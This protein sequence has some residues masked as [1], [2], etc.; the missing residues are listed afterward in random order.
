M[1]NEQCP[2]PLNIHDLHQGLSYALGNMSPRDPFYQILFDRWVE[3]TPGGLTMPDI[4][5]QSKVMPDRMRKFVAPLAKLAAFASALYPT[6][7]YAT[8]S[9]DGTGGQS[10]P[11]PPSIP[12]VD[13]DTGTP[14]TLFLPILSNGHVSTTI[15]FQNEHGQPSD[16]TPTTSVKPEG[17]GKTIYL[18]AVM[19]GEVCK[20]FPFQFG[21]GVVQVANNGMI[22]SVGFIDQGQ[23]V[24][25]NIDENDSA[26][27]VIG[28]VY[29]QVRPKCGEGGKYILQ[30]NFSVAPVGSPYDSYNLIGFQAQ[31]LTVKSENPRVFALTSAGLAPV[32]GAPPDLTVR[33]GDVLEI[34]RIWIG[35]DGAR[36]VVYQDR[37][38]HQF[39]MTADEFLDPD[40][41]TLPAILRPGEIYGED[42]APGYKNAA[43]IIDS[44]L[45]GELSKNGLSDSEIASIYQMITN[46]KEFAPGDPNI[47]IAFGNLNTGDGQGIVYMQTD[48]KTKHITVDANAINGLTID[49]ILSMLAHELGHT[50]GPYGEKYLNSNNFL[51]LTPIFSIIGYRTSGEPIVLNTENNTYVRPGNIV[52]MAEGIT[53]SRAADFLRSMGW[54]DD[55]IWAAEVNTPIYRNS[56]L[57]VE[58]FGVADYINPIVWMNAVRN[59]VGGTRT[60]SGEDFENVANIF[61]NYSNGRI[62]IDSAYQQ[63]KNQFTGGGSTGSRSIPDRRSGM[64]KPPKYNNKDFTTKGFGQKSI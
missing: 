55:R 12:T 5:L 40:T 53:Q 62:T 47:S 50:A 41:H 35:V 56:R 63:I 9:H 28:G 31:R 4:D 3:L 15:S 10:S 13:A 8:Q 24:S 6:I 7:S 37:N 52:M 60:V 42:D 33:K 44:Y 20:N 29:Y 16:I 22:E 23:V 2:E 36:Y 27:F 19:K 39:V 43:V 51:K 32:V 49:Q 57:L 17:G 54:S 59:S 38:S 1:R 64:K 25:V 11:Q 18:P 21:G 34:D 14:N 46:Y 58:K 61:E 26:V 48:W 30:M 45:L